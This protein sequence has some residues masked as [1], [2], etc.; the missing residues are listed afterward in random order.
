VRKREKRS[1]WNPLVFEGGK[2]RPKDERTLDTCKGQKGKGTY[3]IRIGGLN[4]AST[5]EASV[6]TSNNCGCKRGRAD[7]IFQSFGENNLV[8]LIKNEGEKKVVTALNKRVKQLEGTPGVRSSAGER[9]GP[10]RSV[11]G[12]LSKRRKQGAILRRRGLGKGSK[13][14]SPKPERRKSKYGGVLTYRAIGRRNMGS[15]GQILE[16]ER[17]LKSRGTTL[18]IQKNKKNISQK[19]A[20][21]TLWRAGGKK[22]YRSGLLNISMIGKN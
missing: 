3:P 2:E 6:K 14:A 11:S 4:K 1:G 19:R 18:Y 13:K 8:Q 17:K 16:G 10:G 5:S 9:R 22:G 12:P 21:L 7:M 20:R 15:W